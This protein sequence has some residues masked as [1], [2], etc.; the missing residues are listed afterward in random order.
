L[1]QARASAS[2]PAQ[3][4]R[5]FGP[6]SFVCVPPGIVHTFSNPGEQ[7]VRFLNFSTPGGFERYMR[8]L[9]TAAAAGPLTRETMRQI[10]SRHDVQ[11]A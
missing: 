6:G 4:P 11:V 10:A 2:L 9:G 1:D 5:S 8:E 7:P 3:V